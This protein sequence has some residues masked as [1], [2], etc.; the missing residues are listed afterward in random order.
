MIS[1]PGGKNKKLYSY[2]KSMKSDSSGVAPLKKDGSTY[3][4]ASAKAE[5]LNDQFSSVFSSGVAPLKKDGSTYSDASAKA[6][7][8][9]DQFSSVFTKEDCENLPDLGLDIPVEAPPTDDPCQ[10]CKEAT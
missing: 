9:N 4:D 8:L 2:V 7:I 1:E 6:E 5:I 10:W 3:S